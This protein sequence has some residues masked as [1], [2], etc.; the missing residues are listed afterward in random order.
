MK[1]LSRDEMK[2]V[3]GGSSCQALVQ[4]ASGGYTVFTGLSSG[5]AQSQGGMVHW[6]CDSCSSASWAVQ[7]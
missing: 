5:E 7:Q 4:A 1:Q 2:K 6:C 3:M